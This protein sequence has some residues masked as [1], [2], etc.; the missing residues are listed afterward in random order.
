MPR[1]IK[2]TTI[3]ESGG[4][5]AEQEGVNCRASPGPPVSTRLVENR[6]G[7]LMGVGHRVP[8][9]RVVRVEREL[10]VRVLS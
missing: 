7:L 8:L 4:T 6:I 3:E 2:A 1:E 5:V 10:T 9:R